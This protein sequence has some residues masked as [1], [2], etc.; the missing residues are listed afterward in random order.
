MGIIALSMRDDYY[1]YNF[2]LFVTVKS[3]SSAA[4]ISRVGQATASHMHA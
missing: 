3:V 2:F 4:I 1:Y